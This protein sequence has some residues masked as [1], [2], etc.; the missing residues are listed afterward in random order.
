MFSRP[1]RESK[2]IAG[3]YWSGH[4]SE[5]VGMRFL[6]CFSSVALW[7]STTSGKQAAVH[8]V[9][10]ESWTVWWPSTSG[11]EQKQGAELSSSRCNL[12][13]VSWLVLLLGSLL[14]DSVTWWNQLSD[15]FKK[16]DFC[17][18]GRF[19]LGNLFTK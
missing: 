18:K 17:D 14:D 19:F 4:L 3:T 7:I 6:F 13:F 8:I 2:H 9:Q 15:F 16:S 10:R 1:V 12:I 11:F 5:R